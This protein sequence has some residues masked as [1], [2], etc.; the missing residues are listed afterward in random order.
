MKYTA[1]VIDDSSIQRLATSFLVKNHPQLQLAGSYSS[2]YEGIK[3][4]YDMKADIVFLDV[5]MNDVDAFE[6][7]DSIEINA[8]IVMNSTWE[9][10]AKH[11][12]DYGIND[13]WTKPM[14]KK[15]FNEAVETQNVVLVVLQPR[16]SESSVLQGR[17]FVHRFVLLLDTLLSCLVRFLVVEHRSAQRQGVH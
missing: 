5:L 2:P 12:F 4:I 9:K 17:S 8:A 6:L 7:L 10:F 3:A 16:L 13:F 15:R 1:I 11:A 14:P